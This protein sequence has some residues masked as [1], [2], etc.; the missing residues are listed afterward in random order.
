MRRIPFGMIIG[1]LI[2]IPVSLFAVASMAFWLIRL[3]GANAAATVAGEYADAEAIAAVERELGLDRSRWEQYTGFLGDLV[4]GDLGVSYFTRQPVTEEI[5]GRISLDLFLGVLGLIVAVVIGVA[6]G[7]VSAYYRSGWPD[8]LSSTSVGFLQSL[9]DFVI[10]L[11][12][13]YVLFYL[14]GLMPPPV[15]E[16]A[17]DRIPP[18]E[19][20]G[21]VFVDAALSGQWDTFWAAGEQLLL[22]VASMGLGLT[23][24]FAKVTS[25]TLGTV[26]ASPQIE[27]ARACGLSPLRVFWS[28]LSVTRTALLTTVAIIIGALLGGGAVLQKIYNLDGAAAFGVDSIFKLDLPA[29][30]G[31]VIVFG[32]LTV[33]VFLLID[34]LILLLD[35]R[36]Q[37]SN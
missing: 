16:L 19:V 20:T 9:P 17:L 31:I 24:V 18:P 15:G 10:A 1:R 28:A 5:M 13:I 3:S 37:A 21:V 30:Q 8:R 4:R 35:P 11:V 36:V 33:V 7:A 29:I 22:P 14:L 26:L 2:A 6:L 12:L 23:P 25:S 34:I 32:G 27:Y